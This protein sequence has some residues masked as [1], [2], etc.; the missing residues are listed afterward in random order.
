MSYNYDFDNERY[1]CDA[2]VNKK[3]YNINQDSGMEV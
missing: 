2:V 3:T 1:H